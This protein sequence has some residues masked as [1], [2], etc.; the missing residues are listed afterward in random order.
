MVLYILVTVWFVFATLG[1]LTLH[2]ICNADCVE[3]AASCPAKTGADAATCSAVTDLTTPDEC[4][5]AVQCEYYPAETCEPKTPE[6]EDFC[7]HVAGIFLLTFLVL[8][9]SF[10]GSIMGCCVVCCGNDEVGGDDSG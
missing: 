10:T 3:S 9:T 5:A 1:Y 2:G 4:N 8:I 7:A 6:E